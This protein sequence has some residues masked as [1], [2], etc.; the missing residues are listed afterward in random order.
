[1]NDLSLFEVILALLGVL[2]AGKVVELLVNR[3]LHRKVE[4][5][6]ETK[7]KAEVVSQEVTTVRGVLAEVQKHSETKD[8]VI[9]D[10]QFQV[11]SLAGRVERMES[12]EHQGH[13]LTAAHE[14]WDIQAF[15]RLLA[16]DPDFPAPPPLRAPLLIEAHI[17]TQPRQ[18]QDPEDQ[19]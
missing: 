9:K 5:L 14:L 13:Q 15:Q 17:D 1:M 6:S 8:Q 10:L 7:I 16:H 12:R 11:H 19:P 4:V 18:P 2:G 3:L